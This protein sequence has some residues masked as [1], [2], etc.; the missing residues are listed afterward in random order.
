MKDYLDK[1]TRINQKI[2]QFRNLEDIYETKWSKQ[3]F[4]T[5]NRAPKKSLL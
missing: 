1:T 5:Y 3:S 4:T 2:E